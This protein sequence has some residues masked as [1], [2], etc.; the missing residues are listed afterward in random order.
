MIVL[1]WALGCTNPS[2]VSDR[3][4]VP[5]PS[6][7]VPVFSVGDNWHWKLRN[8]DRTWL[9]KRVTAI[10]GDA[11]I[12]ERQMN[13]DIGPIV[14]KVDKKAL[15]TLYL[16]PP[17]R[18]G[19][20]MNTPYIIK[21]PLFVGKKWAM[22]P[23]NTVVLYGLFGTGS[24]PLNI[25]VMSFEDVETPAGRFK[26]FRMDCKVG[27]E[28]FVSFWY[29]PDVRNIIRVETERDGVFELI[30]YSVKDLL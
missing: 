6:C 26:A 14:E 29:A 9:L 11:Y 7:D 22:A 4:T 2:R 10:E 24:F 15:K 21:F 30:S 16:T 23:G 5:S 28:W 13:G 8:N 17:G 19:W 18:H 27:I 12:I 1:F 3:S 20:I 25:Q